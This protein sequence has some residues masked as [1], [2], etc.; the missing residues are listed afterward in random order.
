MAA[1]AGGSLRWNHAEL[2]MSWIV[3]L[4]AGLGLNMFMKSSLHSCDSSMFLGMLYWPLMVR[5]IDCIIAR[6]PTHTYRESFVP[7]LT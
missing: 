3:N 1:S 2:R 7:S 4:F 5:C 6:Q